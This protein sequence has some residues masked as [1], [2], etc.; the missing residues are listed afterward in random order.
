M[1]NNFI[2]GNLMVTQLPS[3]PVVGKLINGLIAYLKT[4]TETYA[5][6]T[7]INGQVQP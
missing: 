4:Q 6:T 3:L 2:R 5:K 7:K 1:E